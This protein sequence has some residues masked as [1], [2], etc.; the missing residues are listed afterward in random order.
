MSQTSLEALANA[1]RYS[2]SETHGFGP[3]KQFVSNSDYMRALDEIARLIAVCNREY[4]R[5]MTESYETSLSVREADTVWES[6]QRKAR[7]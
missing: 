5:G 7:S 4:E 6:Q 1:T 3:L 2:P